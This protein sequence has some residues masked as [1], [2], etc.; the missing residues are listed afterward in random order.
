M[1][2]Q[3][4][5]QKCNVCWNSLIYHTW[6]L[7]NIKWCKIS[8]LRKLIKRKWKQR[9]INTSIRNVCCSIILSCVVVGDFLILNEKKNKHKN[10]RRN[11]LK[12]NSVCFVAWLS[13]VM[14]YVEC[15]KA[16]NCADVNEYEWLLQRCLI[17]CN[18]YCS[19]ILG[20][21]QF[22]YF[23]MLSCAFRRSRMSRC[24]WWWLQG[25]W[26]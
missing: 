26:V 24:A 10:K 8:I 15:P 19:L 9:S 1:K 2:V 11:K 3:Q 25:W 7:C 5:L 4:N 14:Y 22:V 6:S 23:D 21:D 18:L 12:M 13:C 16:K 17:M 20:R